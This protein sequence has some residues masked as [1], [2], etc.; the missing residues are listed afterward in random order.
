MVRIQRL[1][2]KTTYTMITKLFEIRDSGTFIPMI[3]IKL[4]PQNEAERY[5]LGR[6]GFGRQAE[7]HEKYVLFSSLTGGEMTSDP[8]NWPNRTRQ[9]AHIYITEH[10]DELENGQ[11]IDVQFILK[12]TPQPKTTEAFQ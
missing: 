9:V 5:L 3:A 1:T 12:E 2:H 8:Y 10:F 4:S 6:A 7:D 11:V